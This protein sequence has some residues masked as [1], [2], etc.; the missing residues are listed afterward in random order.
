[1]DNLINSLPGIR[2]PVEAVTRTLSHMWDIQS[3]EVGDSPSDFRA[4]QM[5]LILHLGLETTAE[6]AH[7]RF[8][9]AINFAQRYPCRIIVLCPSEPGNLDDLLEAKLFSQCYIGKHL[10]DLCCCE[11]LILGYSIEES[12]FL[13]NQVSLWLESDLPVYHWFNRVPGKRIKDFYLPFIKR[14]RRVLYD[15]AIEQWDEDSLCDVENLR[16]R[17]LAY[18]R[19]LHLRQQLGQFISSVPVE[20]LLKNLHRISFASGPE[21]L[22]E[23]RHIYRWHETCLRKACGDEGEDKVAKWLPGIRE[24]EKLP[25]KAMRIQWLDK[26]GKAFIDWEY[27]PRQRSG[28]FKSSLP[29]AAH[30]SLHHLEPIKAHAAL[31]EA[32]FF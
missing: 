19:T 14:C 32:M 27:L 11:A 1:M 13:E 31:A 7:V 25:G 4:S 3:L 8:D 10:R 29:G 22:P 18:A 5:N 12:S 28:C 24:I 30:Q 23:M 6:E 20:T 26:K 9:T 21:R 2:L 15:S 16:I 17:D